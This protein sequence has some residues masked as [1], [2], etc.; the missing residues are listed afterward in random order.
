M[1]AGAGSATLGPSTAAA[2]AALGTA[3]GAGAALAAAFLL[4][5]Q[6]LRA[7]DPP[8]EAC[9]R[10][11]ARY[12]EAAAQLAG[13]VREG[14]DLGVPRVGPRQLSQQRVRPHGVSSLTA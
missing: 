9:R 5:R 7:L 1:G 13:G 11:F 3:L 8:T 12:V 6:G 14:H 10:P 2:A 4:R